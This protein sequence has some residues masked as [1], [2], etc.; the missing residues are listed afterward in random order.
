[1]TFGKTI[2][3]FLIDGD[4]SGRLTCELS[5]WKAWRIEF[6]VLK[7]RSAQIVLI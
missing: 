6:L 4:P 2:K 5:N 3:M 1:M 7:L